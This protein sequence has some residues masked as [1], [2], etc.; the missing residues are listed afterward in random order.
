MQLSLS[1]RDEREW[2]EER[3]VIAIL[4]LNSSPKKRMIKKPIA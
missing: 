2:R 4:N 1:G 3:G